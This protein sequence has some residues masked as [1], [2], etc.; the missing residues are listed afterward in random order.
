MRAYH[1]VTQAVDLLL[2][3]RGRDNLCV[4]VYKGQVYVGQKIEVSYI[5]GESKAP[6]L[7]FLKL[8]YS[9]LSHVKYFVMVHS[10]N[11]TC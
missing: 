10:I 9:F 7:M 5:R 1:W 4:C 2:G 3:R 8:R 11:N 6:N